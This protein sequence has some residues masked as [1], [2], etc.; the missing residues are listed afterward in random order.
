LNQDSSLRSLR[1]GMSGTH[2]NYIIFFLKLLYEFAPVSG[3][4]IP[5]KIVSIVEI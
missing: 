5:T 3:V 4:W 2:H 1:T